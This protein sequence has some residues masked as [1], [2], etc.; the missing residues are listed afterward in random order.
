MPAPAYYKHYSRD[1][2]LDPAVFTQTKLLLTLVKPVGSGLQGMKFQVGQSSAS[3]CE[4]PSVMIHL[5]I[6]H[7]NSKQPGG[8]MLI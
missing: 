3:S 6:I 1:I 5:L 8:K 4:I 7:L 2:D